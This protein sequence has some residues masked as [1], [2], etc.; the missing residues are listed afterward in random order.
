[1]TLELHRPDTFP[2]SIPSND[3]KEPVTETSLA[4]IIEDKAE[5]EQHITEVRIK[6]SECREKL[7]PFKKRIRNLEVDVEDS[8]TI[9]KINDLTFIGLK[10]QTKIRLCRKEMVPHEDEMN[11]LQAELADLERQRHEL[12]IELERG[13]DILLYGPEDTD[14]Y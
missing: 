1:M 3:D 2:D 13:R 6:I 10:A 9:G 14:L 4:K 12:E 7:L 5:V 11:R 8:R